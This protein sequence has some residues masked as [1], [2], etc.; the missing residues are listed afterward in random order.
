M[1][2]SS[3]KKYLTLILPTA[4]YPTSNTP[5]LDHLRPS[6]SPNRPNTTTIT[7][8]IPAAPEQTTNPKIHDPRSYPGYNDWAAQE[9]ILAACIDEIRRLNPRPR[10]EEP[11]QQQQQQQQAIHAVLICGEWMQLY[12]EVR[13]SETALNG[14]GLWR[15]EFPGGKVRLHVEREAGVLAAWAEGIVDCL[16]IGARLGAYGEFLR[17]N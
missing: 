15:F 13:P 5:V 1:A 7:I 9:S 6:H 12:R 16:P 8:R 3:E 11:P 17:L 2:L 4:L 10:D 14:S